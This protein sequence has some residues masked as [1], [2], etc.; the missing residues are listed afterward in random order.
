MNV[1]RRLARLVGSIAL[2]L[3]VI[4][5]VGSLSLWGLNA[6]GLVQP[7]IV[8]S[9]SMSPAIATGDLLIA[10]PIDPAEIVVGDVLTI[11]SVRTGDLVTHRVVEITESDGA[12]VIRMQ[13]DANNAVD[14]EEYVL[15]DGDPVWQ[16][17]VTIPRGGFFV[18]A[19]MQPSVSIP[20]VLGILAL[21]SLTLFSSRRDDRPAVEPSIADGPVV[22]DED[23]SMEAATLAAS[24]MTRREW[25]RRS[26]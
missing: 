1:V 21:C 2:W 10:T 22:A 7:L 18:S 20:L 26:S 14:A 4:L 17:R 12:R 13:G 25:R 11:R 5:G 9:G 16:P 3:L 23:V 6:A 8:V 24:P 15:H 19:L